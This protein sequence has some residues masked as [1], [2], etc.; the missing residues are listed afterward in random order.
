M[1]VPENIL[2]TEFP[3]ISINC[4][5]V[6]DLREKGISSRACPVIV[7]NNGR[8][9]EVPSNREILSVNDRMMAALGMV[10]KMK[11]NELVCPNTSLTDTE[12]LWSP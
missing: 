3:V 4:W 8:L 11:E 6:R 10:E 7:N 9:F 2:L 1:V 5:Y 12:T